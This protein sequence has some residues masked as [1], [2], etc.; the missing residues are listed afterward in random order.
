MIIWLVALIGRK[1]GFT[2]YPPHILEG[3]EAAIEEET[4]RLKAKQT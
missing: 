3:I 2:G 4:Q 1:L